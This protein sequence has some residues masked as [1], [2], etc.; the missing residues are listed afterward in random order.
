LP[1]DIELRVD[2]CDTDGSATDAGRLA[3]MR[4]WIQYQSTQNSGLT[5]VMCELDD[6]VGEDRKSKTWTLQKLDAHLKS[7]YHSRIEQLVRAF[8]LDKGDAAEAPC[9]LCGVNAKLTKGHKKFREH[10][11]E[12]HPD[13]LE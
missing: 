4:R 10:V 12:K 6:T 1:D 8:Y 13:Q 9:P 5:C 11:Q 3:F 2:L 7:D